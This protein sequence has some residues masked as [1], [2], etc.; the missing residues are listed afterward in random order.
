MQLKEASVLLVDDESVLVELMRQWLQQVVG[1][2]FCAGDGVQALQVLDTHRID[3]VLTDIRMPVMDGIALLKEMKTRGRYTPSLIFITGFADIDVRDAYN[4][5]AE[6]LVEKPIEHDGLLDIMRRSLSQPPGRW[7]KQSDV[8]ASPF[9]SRTYTSLSSALQ[10]QRIAFGRGGFCVEGDDFPEEEPVNIILEFIADGY[11][12]L[13]EGV[14]RWS[15]ENQMGIELTYVAD[16]SLTHAV[17]LTEGRSA[18]IPRTTE[19]D[20]QDLRQVG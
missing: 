8:S 4:L 2:V 13:G 11:V 3:L 20:Y 16:K 1:T 6:A 15:Q 10:E 7:K 17:Q 18:F 5:G 9:L 19:R 12:L 14:I